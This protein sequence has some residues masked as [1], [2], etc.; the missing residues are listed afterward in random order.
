MKFISA[1]TLIAL[2]YFPQQF[3]GQKINDRFG[4][5][6]PDGKHIAFESNR[7]GS[8][9]IFV[10]RSDGTG[11]RKITTQGG[12]S[13]PNWSGNSEALTYSRL[14]D[15]RFF[16][17]YTHH[18]SNSRITQITRDSS[19]N[20]ASVWQGDWIYYTSNRH[21]TDQLRRFN[22]DQ[23]Q[24]ELIMTD[25]EH[26]NGISFAPN[27]Q[28]VVMVTKNP[29]NNWDLIIFNLETKKIEKE[30]EHEAREDSPMWSPN[31][32]KIL[33]SSNRDGQWDV[34]FDEP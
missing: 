15:R 3:F 26:H 10:V 34:F 1:I 27:G 2:L 22:T 18:L 21:Q 8:S 20:F 7:E 14:R 17:V 23:N 32:N 11:L 9:H 19:L 31:G 16:D 29:N 12:H 25:A 6:S 28:R 30:F 4:M 13:G 5:V 33:F 24:D